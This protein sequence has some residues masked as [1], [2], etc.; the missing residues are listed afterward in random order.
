MRSGR[1]RSLAPST[2]SVSRIS[3][4]AAE[5]GSSP[6]T[7]DNAQAARSEP[8][9]SRPMVP[10]APP[11]GRG[12]AAKNPQCQTPGPL[13]VLWTTDELS[14]PKSVP[15]GRSPCLAEVA[16]SSH[17]W[18]RVDVGAI[19]VCSPSPP[20]IAT[21]HHALLGYKGESRLRNPLREICTGS[22]REEKSVV[23]W[24]T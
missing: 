9:C 4:H 11:R 6:S 13:P 3:A 15:P 23:P 10:G 7:C 21:S 24:W 2:S 14:E 19:H 1:G 8:D 18:N 22:V 17:S 12:A 16:Q 5:E 20:S